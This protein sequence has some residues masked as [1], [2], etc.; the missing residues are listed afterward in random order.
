MT[1]KKQKKDKK[2]AAAAAALNNEQKEKE[3]D[4]DMLEDIKRDEDLYISESDVTNIS[5]FIRTTNKSFASLGNTVVEK[6]NNRCSLAILHALTAL[7]DLD[8]TDRDDVIRRLNI[9][10]IVWRLPEL[11]QELR[12]KPTKSMSDVYSH[13]FATFLFYAE[14]LEKHKL[15]SILA[16]IIV[17]NNV[18]VMEKL[19]APDFMQKAESFDIYKVDRLGFE[20]WTE[21]NTDHWPEI[22]EEMVSLSKAMRE[23]GTERKDYEAGMAEAFYPLVHNPPTMLPPRMPPLDAE[24][25]LVKAYRKKKDPQNEDAVRVVYSVSAGT[26]M[27]EKLRQAFIDLE[28]TIEEYQAEIFSGM[29]QAELDEAQRVITFN[30][31]MAES[32]DSDDG[33]IE[34]DSDSEAEA[35]SEFRNMTQTVNYELNDKTLE[36][37]V[38]RVLAGTGLTTSKSETLASFVRKTNMSHPQYQRLLQCSESDENVIMMCRTNVKVAGAF[39]VRNALSDPNS[40]E[41]FKRYLHIAEQL[42][43]IV[44]ALECVLKLSKEFATSNR[45]SDKHRDCVIGYIHHTIKSIEET[46]SPPARS[47]RL[48]AMLVRKLICEG[49]LTVEQVT[50]DIR[51]FCLKHTENRECTALYKM[52]TGEKSEET[53]TSTKV[54]T[55]NQLTTTT[56]TTTNVATNATST[57]TTTT[58]V[59]HCGPAVIKQTSRKVVLQVGIWGSAQGAPDI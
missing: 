58:V 13:P 57:T 54:D 35:E 26:D 55:Q 50:A 17:T 51:A 8:S 29:T 4:L 6:F 43:S 27:Q 36:G 2:A 56:T 25:P 14:Q 30:E 34:I 9:I 18:S 24:D 45:L 41:I 32:S 46:E 47:I 12:L 7:F 39:M 40:F 15:E 5:N 23:M 11:E 49:V 16:R 20:K 37:C 44:H 31:T 53:T 19:T 48:V 21:A 52:L 22:T 28:P 38:D 59:K 10:Y 33:P 3:D 42:N 1:R